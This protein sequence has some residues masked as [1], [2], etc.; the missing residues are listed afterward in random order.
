MIKKGKKC[1]KISRFL[2]GMENFTFRDMH[3]GE[4]STGKCAKM[5]CI[6]PK[7]PDGLVFTAE[8]PN[9]SFELSEIVFQCVGSIESAGDQKYVVVT[10]ILK[11]VT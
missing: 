9:I 8:R 5:G 2:V 6:T 3:V 1:E 10:S 7:Y 11:H 4:K